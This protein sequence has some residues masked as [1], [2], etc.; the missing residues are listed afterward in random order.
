MENQFKHTPEPW[1]FHV[2][3]NAEIPHVSICAVDGGCT[4]ATLGDKGL[5]PD[6]PTEVDVADAERI[7]A[8][9]NGCKGIVDPETAVPELVAALRHLCREYKNCDG[10]VWDAPRELLDKLEG[11]AK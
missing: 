6:C 1:D 7:V 2:A 10:I 9:V 11:G 8:C 5:D 3:D 4:I